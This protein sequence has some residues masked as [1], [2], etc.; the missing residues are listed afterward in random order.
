MSDRKYPVR[1]D[2][3]DER[4]YIY[5]VAAPAALP[6]EGDLRSKMSPVVDQGSIGS[7]TANAIVSGLREYTLLRQG[8]PLTILSRLYLYWHE[9]FYEGTTNQDAGAFIRDGFRCLKEFGCSPEIDWPY[10]TDLLTTAP[11]GQAESNAAA[12]K[13][14]DYH[15]VMDFVSLQTALA[16]GNP[17]VIGIAVYNSFESAD[18]AKTGIIPLPAATETNLGGH[19]LLAVGYTNRID[20]NQPYVI[21][22]NSWGEHWGDA[23]YCYIPKSYFNAG[24]VMDMWTSDIAPVTRPTTDEAFALLGSLIIPG[25]TRKVMASPDTWKAICN[26]HKK[27]TGLLQYL[28]VIFCNIAEYLKAQGN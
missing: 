21:V 23:G 3:H 1:K 15:R 10:L 6:A 7:C 27:D 9:R 11:C 16:A 26:E 22:R 4:D 18:V 24:Y 19:A 28:D 20:P 8:L 25:T 5:S 17:V 12:Y 2:P 13:I 14:Y